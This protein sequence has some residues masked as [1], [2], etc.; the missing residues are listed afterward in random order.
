MTP[1]TTGTP[2]PRPHDDLLGGAARVRPTLV[3]AVVT[4]ACVAPAAAVAGSL[5]LAALA[6]LLTLVTV[7]AAATVI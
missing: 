4:A 2:D 7:L 3:T 1:D 5:A 6:A